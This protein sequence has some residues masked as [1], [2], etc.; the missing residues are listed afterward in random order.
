MFRESPGADHAASHKSAPP[1]VASE[2][3]IPL[4][5]APKHM[6]KRAHINTVRRWADRKRGGYKGIVLKT[7]TFAGQ[8]VTT[9]RAIDEFFRATSAA[10]EDTAPQ[11]P[12]PSHEA[13]ERFLDEVGI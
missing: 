2:E 1:S 3:F 9:I 13:A 6:P 7:W 4:V 11:P 5:E 12:S 10:A 8:R